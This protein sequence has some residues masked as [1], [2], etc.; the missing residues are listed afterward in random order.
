MMPLFTNHRVQFIRGRRLYLLSLL[1]ATYLTQITVLLT[2][3]QW[4]C[5]QYST[6]EYITI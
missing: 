6:T 4:N 5:I 1:S 2:N 3:I